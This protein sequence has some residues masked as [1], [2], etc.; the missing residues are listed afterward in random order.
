MQTKTKIVLS[1]AA[2][3]LISAIIVLVVFYILRGINR[4]FVRVQIYRHIT[5]KTD[6]LNRLSARF[7]SPAEADRI[8]QIKSLRAS[9]ENLLTALSASDSQEE[10]L[11]REIRTNTDNL[12]YALEKLVA[13]PPAPEGFPWSERNNI[14]ISQLSMITQF[15]SDD[16][17]QLAEISQSHIDAAWRQA[18]LLIMV[19]IGALILANA[20]ISFF[21]GRNIVRAQEV[22]QQALNRADE[23]D[24]LLAALM[25]YVPEGITMADAALKLTRVSRYG[26]ELLGFARE[27]DRTE[28]VV[29]Q[30]AVYHADGTTPMA[31]EELP[32]VRAVQV[33]EVLT[34][35]ELVQVD[36]RGAPLPLL[37]NA[38]PI[39]NDAGEIIGGIV[40]W[41]DITDRKQ[42]EE[43]LR[44]SQERLRAS[45]A[46]K[47][48]LLKEI[49]HRVK[50]NMQVISSLVD[51]QADEVKDP[52]MAAIFQ[53][54]IYRVRSMAMV[55]EKLYQSADLARV[56]F[57]D[58]I[59]SLLGYLWRAQGAP[60]SRIH[61]DL[62]VMPVLLPVNLAVPC[63]LIL[64]ELFSN[65][66]KHAF[67]GRDGGSVHVKLREDEQGRVRLSVRDDGVGLP[68]AMDWEQSRSLGLRIV[69]T[70][71]RQLHAAVDVV[72]DA[73][74]Q[75]TIS[76]E[77]MSI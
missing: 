13:R 48:V 11:V 2:S 68:P 53:D 60:A 34:D 44:Q 30:S 39:R 69:K 7:S 71:A 52:A 25:E 76:F 23:G 66:L 72:R 12:E 55:H 74:T 8:A 50:N 56:E 28:K 33:G 63:G 46:E 65:A 73:G 5:Q 77:S 17:R 14:L 15:I 21:S 59:Q 51:L 22:Q 3:F 38:G 58:Y 40:A 31:F 47:E 27:G 75:F 41:R 1:A 16:T 24:R 64:N 42:A 10:A 61:L 18:G 35:I 6:A 20:A 4:E 70:L 26:Q 57:G 45:L 9:I 29:A 32:L 62:D 54:V 49:H 37:C 36:A 67:K 19:L 43:E